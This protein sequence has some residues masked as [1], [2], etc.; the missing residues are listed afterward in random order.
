MTVAGDQAAPVAGQLGVFR[1]QR[2]SESFPLEH[3][4]FNCTATEHLVALRWAES[5][6]SVV[7]FLPGTVVSLCAAK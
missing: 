1:I 4:Q 7:A 2:P 3:L 6:S 5:G